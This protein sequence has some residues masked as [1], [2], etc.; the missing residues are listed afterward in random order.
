MKKLK[1]LAPIFFLAAC[2]GAETETE[3]KDYVETKYD[4]E[5]EKFL[6]D[7]SYKPERQESGLYI[8]KEKEGSDEKPGKN[9]YLTIIYE[10][11]LLD[12]TV[13]DGTQGQPISFDFPM[14]QL[15]EGW[16]EGLPQFGKGGKGTLIVPPDLGYGKRAIGNIPANSVLVFDIELVDFSSEPPLPPD[17]SEEIEAY[18]EKEGM[19]KE[20]AIKTETGMYVFIEKEGGKEKPTVDDFV[21]IYYKGYLTDGFQFDGT[22]DK[23]ATFQLG[24]L[25]PGWKEGIPY[26][27]EG[28]KGK[29][30]IPPHLGYGDRAN[31]D[32]PANSILIFNI[33]LVSFSVEPP[34]KS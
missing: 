8:Y 17:Y 24:G 15:I 26:F 6:E 5:I 29:L 28:G 16:Q 4:K 30:I 12:G 19:D 22:A 34:S 20:D 11:R 33:E 3:E 14:S 2:G 25:I 10:G 7:K 9:D 18:I 32:I 27:G 1:Y 13:F 31:G 21:T 23:P